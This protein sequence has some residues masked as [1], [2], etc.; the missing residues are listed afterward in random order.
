[1]M[2]NERTYRLIAYSAIFAQ[3]NAP[4]ILILNCNRPNKNK[5]LYLQIDL[6]VAIAKYLEK[7]KKNAFIAWVAI[8]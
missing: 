2:T 1:M 6:V 7:Q 3:W 4:S 8:F 5:A